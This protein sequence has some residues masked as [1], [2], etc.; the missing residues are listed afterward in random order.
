MIYYIYVIC[1][2]NQAYQARVHL[3]VLNNNAHLGRDKA[4][5]KAFIIE[6]LGNNQ[7]SGMQHQ[8]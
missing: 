4:K 3:A 7:R 8:H 5:N 6:N 1:S 2:R